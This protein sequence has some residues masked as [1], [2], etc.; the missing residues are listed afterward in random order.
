MFRRKWKEMS[1]G[2]LL[3]RRS[4]LQVKIRF[5]PEESEYLNK[6]LKEI[7]KPIFK[8]MTKELSKFEANR[9]V[10]LM[11]DLYKNNYVQW[12]YEDQVLSASNALDGLRAAKMSR[13]YN[14]KRAKIKREI[15]SIFEEK[16]LEVKKYAKL[17]GLE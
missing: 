9:V 17:E 16:Y 10:Q 4:I 5:I 2:E 15:D 6:Q 8:Y 1:W 14:M 7:N 12:Q 11:S 3:D 13:K